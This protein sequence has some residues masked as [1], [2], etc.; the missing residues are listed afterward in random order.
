MMKIIYFTLFLLS[1]NHLVCGQNIKCTSKTESSI[2]LEINTEVISF[3]FNAINHSNKRVGFEFKNT[4]ESFNAFYKYTH[5]A[6]STKPPEGYMLQFENDYIIINY[7]N[8]HISFI[9]YQN[10]DLDMVYQSTSI[11]LNDLNNLLSQQNDVIRI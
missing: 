7:A 4:I 9:L 10:N 11:T 2:C 8:N 1:F 3:S 5:L 6:F